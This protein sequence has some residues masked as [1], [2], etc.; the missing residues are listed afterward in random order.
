MS[1]IGDLFWRLLPVRRG[2]RGRALFFISL[3]TL[4]SAAQTVGLAGSEA[5]LLSEFGADRLPEAFVLASLVTVLGSFAYASR[6]GSMRN[7]VLFIAILAAAGLV[8]VLSSLEVGSGR[9]WIY[10]ALFCAFY[11]AQAVFINHFWTFS[12]DYFDSTASKR[13]F[14]VFTIGSSIGGLVGGGTAVLLAEVLQPSGLIAAW[15]VLL[16]A[17]ALELR[18]MRRP[19]RRWGPLDLE[20]ADETS[21]DNMRGAVVYVASSRLGIWLCASAV[22]MVL[23]LFISQYLYSD[24]FA[25]AYPDA[26]AL[27]AFLGLY[28]AFTNLLEIVIEV[29]L[30]PWLIRRFGVPTAHL[31]HPILTLISFGGLASSYGLTSGIAARMNRELVEN[32]LAQPIR[33]LAYNALPVRF[34]GR[35]R[36]FVEGIVVY[37][38]MSVAGVLLLVFPD[39]DPLVLCGLGVA[40]ALLYLAANWRVRSAY[41]A[42]LVT[43]IRE[44]HLDLAEISKEIGDWE[45]TRLSGI[46][47]ELLG[48]PQTRVSRS[49]R[50]VVT[51][52][53]RHQI[54]APLVEGASHSSPEVRRLCVEQLGRCTQDEI[55]EVLEQALGDSD[56]EVRRLALQ[57]LIDLGAPA[58]ERHGPRLRA[59]TSPEV[60]ALWAAGQGELD[61]L[62]EMLSLS[63]EDAIAAL[64]H[65]TAALLPDVEAALSDASP[66]VKSAAIDASL[67]LG[68]PPEL[69]LLSAAAN[70]EDANVRRSAIAGLS[71]R[72]DPD[73]AERLAA[74]LAD[75]VPSVREACVHAIAHA[76]GGLEACEPY[77]RDEREST[78][79]AA[80]HAI[81]ANPDPRARELLRSELRHRV[82]QLWFRTTAYQ[83]LPRRHDVAARFL[84]AAY[85]D[86]LLRSRRIAFDL[87]SILENERVIRSVERA[88]RHGSARERGDALEVLSNL[89]DR[90]AAEALVVI[91]EAGSFEDRLL[92]V[93]DL[94]R[95]PREPAA[96]LDASLRS[97]V[98]WIRLA[99]STLDESTPPDENL[100]RTMEQLLALRRISLFSSLTLDQLEAIAHLT[101][102]VTYAPGETIVR[103][104]DSG[105][106]LYLVLEG[107]TDVYLAYGTA[108]QR[109]VNSIEAVD[110]FGEM[111]V[112]DGEPR[113]ATIVAREPCR[114]LTLD[115][116]SLK[117][118]IRQMPEISFGIFRILTERVRDLE[119]LAI[120]EAS[121][122]GPQ[123]SS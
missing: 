18:L 42:A 119:Q 102:E 13:L 74:L 111:A 9:I 120:Q 19:L 38:G 92:A 66:G 24:I 107:V 97:E 108:S 8:L 69:A 81:G 77:L 23:A 6:V 43:V 7:D 83:E 116:D 1:W 70:S 47:R 93:G 14:P 33:T 48:E 26:S 99:A 16:L 110:Y 76:E 101:K 34:R 115:G 82:A 39:A 36:A 31:V 10:P 117:S 118:L 25:R 122:G 28:L 21:V 22:G 64:A 15:G 89:G 3:F 87:L 67:R 85:A 60:R 68:A 29:A 63:P 80:Q 44:G 94:V 12:G 109:R 112:L 79:L 11:L 55:P 45:A 59:D 37:A 46:C 61:T 100:T 78:V 52:L 103:Q 88:L 105:N 56:A 30:T 73:V 53:G 40:A 17:A 65:A 90:Q 98:R 32:A 95:P 20:E 4:V 75:P 2:E 57:G 84:R 72:P 35:L 41:L 5:L 104:G 91:H 27:A 114:L 62:R 86:A 96:L 58:L 50:Q 121:E 113:S 51:T 106:E 49:L 54:S 71:S 123:P